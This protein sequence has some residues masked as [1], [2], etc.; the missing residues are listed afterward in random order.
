MLTALAAHGLLPWS[1]VTT[2]HATVGGTVAADCLSR[3]SPLTGREGVHVRRFEMLTVDGEAIECRRDDPDPDRRL[4]FR[5]VIGGFGYLGV[6]TEVT[7]DL[8]PPLPGWEPGR[9]LR[10]AT[11]ADKYLV[12]KV[13]GGP[14]STFLPRLRERVGDADLTAPRPGAIERLRDALQP[15]EAPEL[16]PWDAVSSAAWFAL[17]QIE[18]ALFRSRYVLDQELR[19]LPI[20]RPSSRLMDA[21]TMASVN[22]FVAELSEGALFAFSPSGVYVDD[23]AD[24][25]WF[26]ENQITPAKAAAAAA[27]W[28][29]DTIQ[30]TFVLPCAP[31]PDDPAGVGPTARFLEQIRAVLFSD[32]EQPALLDPM[33]PTLMDVLYLP[34]DD[35]ILSATR[36]LAGYAVTLA[37]SERDEDG[38]DTL[39]ARLEALS[40]TCHDLGGRV[41]LIK[42]VVAPQPLLEEMYGGAFAEFLALKRRYDPHGVLENAFFERVFGAQVER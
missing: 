40:R 33:R 27:G 38:W 29:L 23:L 16:T 34:A 21:V 22:P 15:H 7:I 28:R 42:D 9:T 39:Q 30:Q 20:Y 32:P 6:L 36:G 5:A 35:F 12:G 18:V 31:G 8:R 4:L 14:W 11:R 3:S 37:F 10:V 17:G 2:S 26:M 24:F 13:L 25:T 19:P 41:H 1:L